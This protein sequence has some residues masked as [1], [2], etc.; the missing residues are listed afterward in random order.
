MSPISWHLITRVSTG[1]KAS[2]QNKEAVMCNKVF[3][4]IA[5]IIISNL[6]PTLVYGKTLLLGLLTTAVYTVT[7]PHLLD[8]ELSETWR[9]VEY[10]NILQMSQTVWDYLG[11]GSWKG[12]MYRPCSYLINHNQHLLKPGAYGC[13]FVTH[14]FKITLVDVSFYLF[15]DVILV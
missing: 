6:K 2:I 1:Q 5:I 4:F 8:I 9:I 7:T 12:L 10:S 3:E 11:I 13:I 14:N 15:K